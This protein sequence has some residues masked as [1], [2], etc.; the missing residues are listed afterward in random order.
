MPRHAS[1]KDRIFEIAEAL[2][3]EPE[4]L[5]RRDIERLFGISRTQA[6]EL[7]SVVGAEKS[8]GASTT[9]RDAVAFY[10]R[11]SKAWQEATDEKE[12]RERLNQKLR[13]AE[14]DLV[15]R[16][17]PIPAQPK[18]EWAKFRDLAPNV[19]LEPGRLEIRFC[20]QEDLLHQLWL[21]SR[22]MQNQLPVFDRLTGVTEEENAS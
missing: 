12:R 22:A 20:G 1:W 4:I 8:D 15:L 9:R 17:T 13:Q 5:E 3:S 16:E 7:M 19:I 21:L 6:G 11:N 14:E 10:L 2:S 18:D